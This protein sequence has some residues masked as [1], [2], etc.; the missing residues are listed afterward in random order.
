MNNPH[1]T[2]NKNSKYKLVFTPDFK[3]L[4]RNTKSAFYPP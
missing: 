1:T 4:P 3:M 2:I